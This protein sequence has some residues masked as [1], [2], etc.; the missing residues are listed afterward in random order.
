M[1]QSFQ[2][3]R[4]AENDEL[5]LASAVFTPLQVL[6]QS[7][8]MAQ[9]LKLNIA[10]STGL[11][12]NIQFPLPST[13]IW[14]LYQ[15]HFDDLPAESAFTKDNLC[16]KIL[17]ILP[18]ML[19]QDAFLLLRN[20]LQDGESPL[21][22]YQLSAKIADIYDQYLMYRPDWVTTWEQG[23]DTLPDVDVSKQPWQ[24][25][26][27]RR[28]VKY[29]EEL[30]ESPYHRANMHTELLTRLHADNHTQTPLFIFGMSTIPTPQLEVF[31][32][33]AERQPVYLFWL[34]PSE[35]FWA[36]I[37]DTR[38]MAKKQLSLL[39]E[40]D[41]V[42]AAAVTLSDIGHPLL[43]SWGKV[44]R[45]FLSQLMDF[46]IEQDDLFT[47]PLNHSLLEKL[48]HDIFALR[49]SNV[50][51]PKSVVKPD[52]HSIQINVAHSPVRELEILRERIYH[53]LQSGVIESVDEV[54]VMMPD[55]AQY[56]PYID[57]VF[58]SSALN[59]K[60]IPYAISDRNLRQEY[61]LSETLLVL[62]KLHHKRL[63]F[64]EVF[65]IFEMAAVLTQFGVSTEEVQVL[66]HWCNSVNIRW[67]L[68]AAD[69]QRWNVPEQGNNTWLFGLRRLL[70]GYACNQA[71]TIGDSDIL[72]F[73]AAEGQVTEALGK[74]ITFV[75][76]LQAVL[77]ACQRNETLSAKVQLAEQVLSHFFAESDDNAQVFAAI[78]EALASLS[79]HGLQYSDA[80]SQDVFVAALQ[81]KMDVS[82]VGQ[83]FLTG[84]VNFTTLMPMRS[85]PFK[86]VC[87]LGMNDS[88][89]PRQVVP[90]GFDLMQYSSPRRGDRARRMDDRYLFLEALISARQCFYLSYVGRSEQ[91]NSPENP[92]ILI[93]ELLEYCEQS[94]VLACEDDSG[95]TRVDNGIDSGITG[96]LVTYFPLQPF[97]PDNFA[98]QPCYH[99]SWHHV[100]DAMQT[101]LQQ[102]TL[103]C[104]PFLVLQSQNIIATFD[105]FV[106]QR[107]DTV[108]DFQQLLRCLRNP[109]SHYFKHSWHS[110]FWSADE[111]AEEHEPLSLDSLSQY[112]LMDD[113]LT[114]SESDN[115]AENWQ[116][117]GDIPGGQLGNY[118]SEQVMANA[119]S[120]KE[121]F[122]K[123][124]GIALQSII[125]V[126][127]VIVI[128][129]QEVRG[130]LE[131]IDNQ[132]QSI[133]VLMRPGKLRLIDQLQL[134]M[135]L[136]FSALSAKTTVECGYFAA[137]DDII[138]M[139]SP[140]QEQANAYLSLLLRFFELAKEMP[141]PFFPRAAELWY[142]KQNKAL[143]IASYVEDGFTQGEGLDRH[144]R[145]V[146]PD[147][148]PVFDAFAYL[149]E[150][151]V[152]PVLSGEGEA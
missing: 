37:V 9:W 29:T 144:A 12:A 55:V 3:S 86:V 138:R 26:L 133:L 11:M 57:A 125:V 31:N 28:L 70:S 139:E 20:Y 107:P 16:W 2:Q 147:L 17:A 34:N 88:D 76:A 99:S 90:V 120:I 111:M 21:K 85:I 93:S 148:E 77:S 75:E 132:Q 136:C 41:D 46:P 33:L 72:P 52:D 113:A 141:L 74:F 19:D 95:D 134:Y 18:D 81:Q 143:T 48:Q 1:L 106:A 140:T 13:Y 92:S 62:L 4:I 91:D 61:S 121:R 109:I 73:P 49:E 23:Q 63:N 53:W 103:S 38:Q 32:A 40:P 25:L 45:D 128:G 44:G 8:G 27:W 89:Y 124:T 24:P 5:D 15:S 122:H 126:S 98:L 51:V 30:G 54:V 6:V 97:H 84:R 149:T 117:T 115:V 56:G 59:D 58:S 145:R 146:Y 130:R 39:L 79:E 71:T 68:N 14:S 114:S 87:L 150:C 118:T 131:L 36:D 82:G 101:R 7:P 67:G 137:T 108:I 152:A 43:A 102:S 47:E 105:S 50:D 10:S 104:K 151:L 22:L 78:R 110:Q 83:R 64:N 94:Y 35:H 119:N 80:I 69:K 96:H 127:D 123:A 135:Q 42:K 142:T 65:A 112:W 60:A 116:L 66:K 100:A 129:E